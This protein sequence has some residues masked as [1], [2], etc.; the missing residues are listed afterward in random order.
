MGSS[1]T[2]RAARPEL[3]PVC[4]R[5]K[6]SPGHAT[7]RPCLKRMREYSATRYSQR[8]AQGLCKQCGQPADGYLCEEHAALRRS[9]RRTRH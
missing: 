3:C 8:R 6:P 5:R 2:T 9:Q 7:C 4:V 1:A